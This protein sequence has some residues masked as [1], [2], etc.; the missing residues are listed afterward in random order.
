[1]IELLIVDDSEAHAGKLA[2]EVSSAFGNEVSVEIAR[3]AATARLLL[4][5]R[6]FDLMVLDLVLPQHDGQDP[7]P[8]NS[9]G[10]LLDIQLGGLCKPRRIVGITMYDYARIALQD[11]FADYLWT[12]VVVSELSNR[13]IESI[14]SALRWIHDTQ[15]DAPTEFGKDLLVMSAL[16]DPEMTAVHQLD[17]GWRG[18]HPVDK[19]IFVREGSFEIGGMRCDVVTSS[20][21]RMGMVSTAIRASRLISIFRP[22]LCVMVGICAGVQDK[23]DIGDPILA[24]PVWDYQTGKRLISEGT[25][26]F[27]IAPHQVAI[28]EGVRERFEIL[29][30]DLEI[31]RAIRDGWSGSPYPTD[32]RLYVG[33]LA[34]GGAVL[35]DGTTLVDFV[36]QQQRQLIGV[37][38]ELY[39]LYCACSQAGG[40]TPVFFGIKSV[41]DF[42][43]PY[44][45]DVH[46]RYAAYTSARTLDAFVRR[47]YPEL[48]ALNE[49]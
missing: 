44:K 38:M 34:S 41:C 43:D 37:D 2:K 7:S 11:F 30:R 39:G 9:R 3:S 21:S 35:A 5:Q 28:H 10:L 19:T 14:L 33:P 6:T 1:M 29:R 8:E 27:E 4:G 23:V 12:L 22:R 15:T 32:V 25:V 13:W 20:A 49:S 48:R 36:R 42:A 18:E 46:Q 17:W 47:F 24:D 40:R 16:A 45:S 31:G 26:E